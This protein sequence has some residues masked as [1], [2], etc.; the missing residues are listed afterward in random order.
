MVKKAKAEGGEGGVVL[1][2]ACCDGTKVSLT[3][4]PPRMPSRAAHL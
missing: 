2:H 3:L 1:T 4:M